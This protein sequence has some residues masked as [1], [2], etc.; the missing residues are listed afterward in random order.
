M[1]SIKVIDSQGP[2]T[3]DYIKQVLQSS[4]AILN[5]DEELAG[6]ILQVSKWMFDQSNSSC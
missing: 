6:R 5:A 1:P 4:E 3:K 2:L